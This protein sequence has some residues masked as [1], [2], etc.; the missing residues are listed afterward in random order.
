MYEDEKSELIDDLI[1]A[2]FDDN[3][4]RYYF[5]SG[6]HDQKYGYFDSAIK[7]YGMAKGF[8]YKGGELSVS[9]AT[10]HLY[11]DRYDLAL[12]ILRDDLSSLKQGD[13]Y[14]AYMIGYI[15][16]I[17]S[18]NARG[19]GQLDRVVE[20]YDHA[21][22]E[23]YNNLKKNKP[24]IED[25][26]ISDIL[27]SK[28]D[29]LFEKNDF[30]KAIEAYIK[31]LKFYPNNSYAAHNVGVI[32]NGLGECEIAIAYYNLAFKIEKNVS[33]VNYYNPE[34]D[35]S[36]PDALATLMA[37]KSFV[38]KLQVMLNKLDVYNEPID[39]MY[40]DGTAEGVKKLQQQWS[41]DDSS[42][43]DYYTY[44]KMLEEY[45]R[46]KGNSVGVYLHYPRKIA[47][48]DVVVL[49]DKIVIEASIISDEKISSVIVENIGGQNK[50]LVVDSNSIAVIK[51]N[52]INEYTVKASVLLENGKNNINIKAIKANKS[53]M[54]TN[55]VVNK[56]DYNRRHG[57]SWA[58][59]VGVQKYDKAKPAELAGVRMG[60]VK[61]VEN[62]IVEQHY[63]KDKVI[64]LT[65]RSTP[66][67]NRILS[68]IG[69]NWQ[70]ATI[71]NIVNNWNDIVR[72]IKNNDSLLIYMVGHGMPI[73]HKAEL[74]KQLQDEEVIKP[75]FL[76]CR[77]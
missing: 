9:L 77:F 28:G 26:H 15:A 69:I 33:S 21:I 11:S 65:D 6:D 73:S 68:D 35:D 75:S 27:S 16:K 74:W 53:Q 4:G 63:D 32:Y 40:N 30:V 64:L 37:K 70:R 61:I 14:R 42:G 44:A 13:P 19:E 56:M 46:E 50:V 7:Y 72:N 67:T 41:L 45:T 54:S 2:G 17:V 12:S 10:C 25:E 58:F 55:V 1:K 3:T 62:L 24:V 36:I 47:G 49:E 5:A 51:M 8:N 60:V 71:N 18:S 39:G 38:R 34:F 66:A 48:E 31:A 29:A 23:Y 59:V 22:K 57:N 43:I 76:P 52:G 20:A